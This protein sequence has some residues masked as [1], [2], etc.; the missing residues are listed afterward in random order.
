MTE[1]EEIAEMQA[2]MAKMRKM[3]ASPDAVHAKR[4][5]WALMIGAVVFGVLI[6]TLPFVGM[7]KIENR[8]I[9]RYAIFKHDRQQAGCKLFESVNSG[10]AYPSREVWHCGDVDQVW[11][12]TGSKQSTDPGPTV[13]PVITGNGLGLGIAL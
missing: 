9:E 2:R 10:K 13:M 3:Y 6:V 7:K 1:E 5:G 11:A 4:T 12:V 8:N